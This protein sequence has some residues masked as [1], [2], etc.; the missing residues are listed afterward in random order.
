MLR[1]VVDLRDV[2]Y[3]RRAHV[4]HAER[5]DQHA[6]ICVLGR[7][8]WRDLGDDVTVVVGIDTTSRQDVAQNALIGMAVGVDEARDDDSVRGIDSHHVGGCD[9]GSDLTN[10]AGLDQHVGVGE[11]ADRRVHGQHQAALEQDAA[12]RSQAGKLGIGALPALRRCRGGQ[13]CAGG[14]ARTGLQERAARLS[15]F[16]PRLA[17]GRPPVVFIAASMRRAPAVPAPQAFP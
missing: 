12:L 14:Q 6:D 15:G 17:H 11:M 4:D 10:L 7:I 16:D 13:S 3:P 1:G 2:D 8:G 5:G 9:I